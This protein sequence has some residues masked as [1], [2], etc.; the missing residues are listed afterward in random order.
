MSTAPIFDELFDRYDAWYLRNR[1]LA[2]LELRTASMLV[3]RGGVGL[4]IGVGTGFFASNLGV[5]LGLDP[6]EK[7]LRVAR[8]R[9]VEVVRGVGELL[10]FRSCSVDYALVVVT[11]CFADDPQELLREAARIVRRGG[12]VIA[13]IVPRESPWGRRYAEEGRAGHP[14]YSAAQFFTVAEVEEMMRRAGLSIDRRIGVLSF[15][16]GTPPRRE[17][18]REDGDMEDMGFVCVRGVKK[19]SKQIR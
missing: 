8:R 15:P 6:S 9:G 3:P 13:C 11:I 7:M 4:E 17:E 16:P 14:F 18:P 1:L 2:E 19:P 12:A 5:E 10:P